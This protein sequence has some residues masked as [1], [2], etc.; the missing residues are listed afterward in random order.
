MFRTT[1]TL[2][3]FVLA[4]APALANEPPYLKLAQELGTP[5][6]ADSAGPADKSRLLLHFV[7]EGEDA[8]TWT[9]MTTVSIL[10]VPAGDTETAAR[11]VIAQLKAQLKAQKATIDVFDQSPIAPVTCFFEFTAA[12][13]T[14]RGVVYSPDPGFVTVAQ[15]SLKTG[16]PLAAGDL[17]LLK[18]LIG[19]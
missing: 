7:R 3:A 12:G 16:T 15:L 19:S 1:L 2:M 13:E 17:K 9:K 6:L 8:T 5:H 14:D 4:A 18:G 11:S 10:Q